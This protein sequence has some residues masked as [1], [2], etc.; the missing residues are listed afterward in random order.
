[1]REI[2][3]FCNNKRNGHIQFLLQDSKMKYHLHTL[4]KYSVQK[5]LHM[6]IRN[7]KVEKTPFRC[8]LKIVAKNIAVVGP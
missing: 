4:M 2:L 6:G 5:K 1:M 7:R 3:P 8:D